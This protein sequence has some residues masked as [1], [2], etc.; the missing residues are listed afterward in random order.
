MSGRIDGQN[1]G[2]PASAD[3]AQFRL[4]KLDS[5]GELA[6][7]GADAAVGDVKGATLYAGAEGEMITIKQWPGLGTHEIAAAGAIA[8]QA[9]IYAAANGMIQALPTDAG[10]YLHLGRALSA[11]DGVGEVVEVLPAVELETVTVSS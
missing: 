4:C 10:T 11:A 6:Y 1:L 3:L 2:F 8:A 5:S 7:L 9:E